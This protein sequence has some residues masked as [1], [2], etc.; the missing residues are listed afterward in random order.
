VLEWVGLLAIG[1]IVGAYAGSVGAGGGF[2]LA[3]VLL[4]RHS[5]A[6]PEEITTATLTVV[7]ISNATHAL[8][9]GR[10]RR[11]DRP[12]AALLVAAALPTAVLGAAATA[13]LP[14]DVFTLGFALLLLLT[15]AYLVRRPESGIVAPV[16][17]GWRREVRDR[18]GATFVYRVPVVRGV[19]AI[20]A[21]AGVSTLAGIGGGLL[22]SPIA[23]RMMR[24][25]HTLAVPL[26]QVLITAVATSA[27]LL[28]LA[29]GHAGAPR[30]DA[31]ALTVGLLASV[32]VARR[33]HDR[34]GEGVLTRA[35]AAGLFIVGIR[36]AVLAL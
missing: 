16:R 7:A 28:H 33:I 20:A 23:T 24:I 19:T 21:A 36:T 30:D 6:A 34:L 10:R 27:V 2:L 18:E 22:Y 26:A 9:A 12:L 15:G 8:Y 11:M 17:E 35:L 25:P 4:L 32:P 31:P 29:A 13:L 3:P 1:F 14:R 5:E